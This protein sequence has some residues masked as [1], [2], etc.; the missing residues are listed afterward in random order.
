MSEPGWRQEL[1]HLPLYA[2]GAL[3][4]F[5]TMV[6]I[7]MF[8]ELR[9]SFDASS[10]AVGLGFTLYFLPFA[11]LL[12]VSGTIGERFGRRRTVRTTYIA[13]AVASI[14]CAIAPNLGLFLVARLVQGAA[15]AFIT[16]LLLAGLADVVPEERVGRVVGIYASF[17]AL[18]SGL[19]PLLGG[20]A[21][22]YNWRW[23]FV[24]TGIV[25]AGL[26]F[27]PPPGEPRH[28][29]RPPVKP[30]LSRRM[31]LLGFGAFAAATGPIGAAFLVGVAARDELGLT[32]GEAGLLLLV[33]N[34]AAFVLG[35]VWGA[36]LD[37][38]GSRRSGV[39][40]TLVLSALIASLALADDT[41]TMTLVWIVAGAVT[42]FVIVVFQGASAVA[43]PDNRGGALSSVLAWRFLGHGV[44]PVV[45]LPVFERSP[46]AAFVGAGALGLVTIAVFATALS[47][48]A[49]T[50]RT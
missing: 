16:P 39:I 18:G 2:G 21:A 23:A 19:A 46:E 33:G 7:P 37:D 12:T 3:G 6:I 50:A 29:E 35:P 22:D 5:G 49:A 4:P 10:G 20:V 17:Q 32:G 15:N 48:P 31:L 14:G 45:W 41:L 27:F 47:P 43:V 44:G 8:P 38:W 13:Y 1:T 28:V 25:A 26:A 11:A 30:L 40:S 42:A 24:G 36:L 9:E 34:L